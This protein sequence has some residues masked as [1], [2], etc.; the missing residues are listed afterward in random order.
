LVNLNA[1]T[2]GV[3]TF[4]LNINLNSYSSRF[5]CPTEYRK[6]RII[7]KMMSQHM[8]TAHMNHKIKVFDY[9]KTFIVL[10]HIF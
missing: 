1:D 2:V 9:V 3:I 8:G 6:Q 7:Q 4:K 10:F 5:R